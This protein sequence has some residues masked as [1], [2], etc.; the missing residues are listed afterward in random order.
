MTH[1]QLDFHSMTPPITQEQ[2]DLQ[3]QLKMHITDLITKTL[4]NNPPVQFLHTKDLPNISSH[5]QMQHQSIPSKHKTP[6]G[7][8]KSPETPPT[9]KKK[10]EI[11]ND[12]FV[13]GL[14]S[15]NTYKTSALH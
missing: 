1:A 11:I 9:T 15:I 4:S 14:S 12:P 13:T 5:D 3:N 8:D 10:Y 6:S 7:H 2:I